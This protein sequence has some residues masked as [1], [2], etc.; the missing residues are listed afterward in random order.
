MYLG[1]MNFGYYV[2]M[3]SCYALQTKHT[4]LRWE[5]IEKYFSG[6]QI[7][8]ELLYYFNYVIIR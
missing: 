3:S 5:Q 1:T 4:E 7:M 8:L 6:S 2:A